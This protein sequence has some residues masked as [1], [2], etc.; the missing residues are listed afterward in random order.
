MYHDIA[1]VKLDRPIEDAQLKD[2]NP[3][4]LP[5]SSYNEVGKSVYVV[6]VGTVFQ[7]SLHTN[8]DGPEPYSQCAPG[9][10]LEGKKIKHW[11][12]NSK[13]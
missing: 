13:G 3:I 6:G 7:Q 1:L 5:S 11:E 8:G 2:Y 12:Q 4:C 9:A 10:V